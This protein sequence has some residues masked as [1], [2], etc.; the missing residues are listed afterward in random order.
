MHF[1]DTHLSQVRSHVGN[2]DRNTLE[3]EKVANHSYDAPAS[4]IEG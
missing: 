3:I 2:N 4:S 1:V